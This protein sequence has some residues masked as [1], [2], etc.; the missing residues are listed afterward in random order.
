[1]SPQSQV[2]HFRRIHRGVVL[3]HD[4]TVGEL[5]LAQDV[6]F[7]YVVE[8]FV[9]STDPSKVHSATATME[10]SEDMQLQLGE[11]GGNPLHKGRATKAFAHIIRSQISV[12]YPS[13]RAVGDEHI[14]VFRYLPP[15]IFRCAVLLA[16][17]VHAP[18][19]SAFIQPLT[20]HVEG[21]VAEGRS[22]R[23]APELDAVNDDRGLLKIDY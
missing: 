4:C 1:M 6:L 18:W 11:A 21:P 5:Y 3:V 19:A 23:R 10:V 2:K 7:G 8:P 9:K 20:C 17:K 22:P 13:G 12:E 16:D 14:G 15:H